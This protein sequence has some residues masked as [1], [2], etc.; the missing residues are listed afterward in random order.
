MK[1]DYEKRT[2]DTHAKIVIGFSAEEAPISEIQ[3]DS[4]N[5]SWTSGRLTFH[6]SM[7]IDVYLSK[8][9]KNAFIASAFDA[10]GKPVSLEHERIVI[11]RTPATATAI[12][13]SQCVG[14][15]ILN[16]TGKSSMDWLIRKGD[17]LPKKRK[18]VYR[19]SSRID[20][21]TR[22]S[23]NFLLLEGESDDPANNRPIGLVSAT[24]W[25]FHE[26]V[27]N[28][29][30]ELELC[31]EMLAS[32]V[33]QI[34]VSIPSI[35][36][37]IHANHHFYSS[38][39]GQIDLGNESVRVEQERRDLY[40]R[41]RKMQRVTYH[42][43]LNEALRQLTSSEHLNNENE[44]NFEQIQEKMEIIYQA[45]DLVSE[46][47][48]IRRKD[49]R[50]MDLKSKYKEFNEVYAKKASQTEIDSVKGLYETA[51]QSVTKDDG[52]FNNDFD[53]LKAGI[54]DVQWRQDWFVLRVFER[55][56]EMPYRFSDPVKFSELIA[57]GKVA[58]QS[59]NLDEL[60]E[61]NWQLAGIRIE[62]LEH[63]AYAP[64]QAVN[65]AAG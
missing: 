27:T 62:M 51:L 10:Q 5:G 29:G 54:H 23:L 6:E 25:S 56:A 19:A 53:Q 38:Q 1:I 33:I 44:L 11:T 61:I 24:G 55:M 2:S 52:Q 40:W 57:K 60:R 49:I 28:E 42:P 22:D 17:T 50:L 15:G 21:G 34:E 41:I 4:L 8:S 16:E 64:S 59:D 36:T 48:Q 32:G 26:G 43:K 65:I 20:A 58:R 35:G 45:H 18:K 47:E 30:D 12:R 13:A 37:I 31:F 9:G 46:V 14:I 7:T 39:N 63:S 3:I